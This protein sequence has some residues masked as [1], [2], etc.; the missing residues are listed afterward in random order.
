MNGGSETERERDQAHNHTHT[1][2]LHLFIQ[3]H[4]FGSGD[5]FR[6]C[7]RVS[8]PCT[9]DTGGPVVLC[10][11]WGLSSARR[12]Q[13]PW[14]PPS[15][16]GSALPGQDARKSLRARPKGPAWLAPRAGDSQDVTA[17]IP[18]PLRPR[19]ATSLFPGVWRR[20]TLHKHGN[21]W[22][23]CPGRWR[24]VKGVQRTQN[25]PPPQAPS[26]A[27]FPLTPTPGGGGLG[28]LG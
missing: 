2:T 9:T 28:V 19:P 5:R 18:G 6:G 20:E 4:L 24:E 23:G 17:P 8:H 14:P 13:H 1:H 27:P 16:C 25:T 3:Q 12:M 26:T 21:R 10:W 15:G 7:H 11:G 22:P